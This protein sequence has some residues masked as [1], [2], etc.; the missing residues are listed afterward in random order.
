MTPA[1]TDLE[2]LLE[3]LAG[4]AAAQGRPP[5]LHRY[6]ADAEHVADLRLPDSAGP[7]PVAVLLHGGFWRAGFTRD[8]MAALACDLANRGWATWNVEYRRV[9]RGGGPI[10]TLDDVGAA[11]E[12]LTGIGSALDLTGLVVIGHSAG[13][14]LA[15]CCA[16]LAA[17]SAVVSL[18]GVCDLAAA[19]HDAIGADAAVQFVGATPAQR[20]DLYAHADP[21]ARLPTG[22]PVLLVHGDG[23]DR[24]P[25]GQSRT[26]ARAA[27]AAG[28]ACELLELAGVDHFAV[29]DP[30]SAAW[31]AVAARLGGGR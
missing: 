2:R 27:V 9:G 20:P 13:G 6:G 12:A 23:D 31:A 1:P 14:Q 29:I 4:W 22:A 30:R 18:A 17:V 25:V 19:A 16:G 3:E 24:V 28:D 8:L 7:H 21:M 10:E 11:I 26:Y 15:L 5:A